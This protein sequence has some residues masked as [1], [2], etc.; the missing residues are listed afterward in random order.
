MFKF[1]VTISA[2][3]LAEALKL[4]YRGEEDLQLCG[5]SSLDQVSEFCLSFSK[6][7]AKSEFNSV[8]IT[9]KESL[10]GNVILSENPRFDFIRCLEWISKNI[11]FEQISTPPKIHPTV[12]L[13][14]NVVV[15]NGVVIDEGTVV[16]HNVVLA[17][18]TIIGKNCLIRANA[19][20]GSDGFGYERDE[21]GKPVKFIHLGYV[22]IGDDV[23]IGAC[24]CI[25]RGTL[26]N[27]IIHNSVKIDN[28]VH[29]AHNCIIKEG[30]FI[31]ACAEVSGGVEIGE[32]SWVAPNSSITQKVK[33]GQDSLIGIGAVVTKNVSESAVVAG[34]PAK[35]LRVL[36]K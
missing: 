11:A 25:A 6:S 22:H 16:E 31:I 13:G 9:T 5:V 8:L 1:K 35:V 3:D 33:V 30:V 17:E 36:S 24:T 12:K 29:I 26:S 19:S 23:E 32:R 27:T 20:I 18:G 2:I 14:K 34:N 10:H 7:N 28:L 21:V 15:E 4:E